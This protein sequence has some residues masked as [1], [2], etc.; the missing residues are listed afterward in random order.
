M[1][2]QI[3]RI[4]LLVTVVASA[5]G[6]S[7]GER[8]GDAVD[9]A[10]FQAETWKQLGTWIDAYPECDDGYF[11]EH[12]SEIVTLWLSR[13][14][15][16]IALLSDAIES[17]ESLKPLV[18]RHLDVLATRERTAAIRTNVVQRC[19]LGAEDLCKE[20]R[21]RLDEL[22]AEIRRERRAKR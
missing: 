20:L 9:D 14:P 2:K 19:P 22:D 1:R 21:S 5:P 8:C 12:I 17:H 6:S 13:S 11:S 4:L 18:L 16:E 10:L 15:R 7:A 3:V